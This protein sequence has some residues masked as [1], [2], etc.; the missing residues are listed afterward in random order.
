MSTTPEVETKAGTDTPDLEPGTATPQHHHHFPHL[1]SKRFTQFIHPHN[2]KTVH[3]C[4][5]PEQLG[6]RSCSVPDDT[7]TNDSLEQKKK[8]L[9]QEKKA[10]EFDVL[11]HGSSDHLEVRAILLLFVHRKY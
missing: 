10:D 3:I 1:H 5:S 8:E 4:R 7:S 9:L 2:G 11:L 6:Q